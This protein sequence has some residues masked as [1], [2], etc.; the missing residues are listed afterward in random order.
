MHVSMERYKLFRTV[1]RI[2]AAAPNL[3]R[4]LGPKENETNKLDRLFMV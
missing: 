1:S 2:V 3:R 4:M